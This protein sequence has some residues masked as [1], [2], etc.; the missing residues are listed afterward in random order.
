MNHSGKKFTHCSPA[1]S[2]VGLPGTLKSVWDMFLSQLSPAW[3]TTTGGLTG[4][5]GPGQLW[6]PSWSSQQP[7]G[8]LGHRGLPPPGS[9]TTFLIAGAAREGTP[10]P[11]RVASWGSRT[12]LY[13][14]ENLEASRAG[15]RGPLLSGLAVPKVTPWIMMTASACAGLTMCHPLF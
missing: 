13:L 7:S 15:V 1:T 9:R 2:V 4:M 8:C 3:L 5:V 10:P 14:Q 12:F 11:T 6:W